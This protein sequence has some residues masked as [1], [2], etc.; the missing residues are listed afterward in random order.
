MIEQQ[1]EN[2]FISAFDLTHSPN[3]HQ[4]FSPLARNKHS[5]TC[6]RA[7]ERVHDDKQ[8]APWAQGLDD[9]KQEDEDKRGVEN[10]GPRRRSADTTDSPSFTH[11][12]G[13]KF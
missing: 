5:S 1:Q 8:P 12:H 3:F 13:E 6:M 7:Q 4:N 11:T 9:T 2:S 10:R